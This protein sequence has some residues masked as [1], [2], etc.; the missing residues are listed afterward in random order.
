MPGSRSR[1]QRW[2]D[3]K[4]FLSEVYSRF[5][6]D[7]NALAAGAIAFFTLL[8]MVPLLLLA[9]AF[10]A[11]QLTELLDSLQATLGPLYAILKEQIA[12]FR[13]TRVYSVPAS[14][15]FALWSGSTIFFILESAINLA[16]HSQK[17]RPFW[18]RRMLAF[19]MVILAGSLMIGAALLANLI[20]VV[21]RWDITLFG[22]RGQEFSWLLKAGVTFVVPVLLIALLFAVIYRV[23]PTR[24]VT[25]RV[26]I[27]GALFS[28]VLWLAA[29]H[30]LGLYW[31]TFGA[32]R[33]YAV[34][35]GSLTGIFL[36]M[37][38]LYYGA[39]IFLLGAEISVVYHKRLVA[40]GDEEERQVEEHE[41][42]SAE[43]EETARERARLDNAVNA[44]A[45]YGY[46][47]EEWHTVEEREPESPGPSRP[48]TR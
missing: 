19:L 13:Y 1:A 21:S 39:L 18:L 20:T 22:H 4:S 31:S 9:V 15:L 24:R 38:L 36:L 12:Y 23:L 33:R 29:L 25:F 8:S 48:G 5:G 37:I 2:A 34:V 26:V 35:Y 43:D 32:E 47:G 11:T 40:A 17:R 44:L 7:R 14:L 16:W 45:Y 27:P 42:L 3:I 41:K 46:Q 6:E 28:A 30:L 10:A